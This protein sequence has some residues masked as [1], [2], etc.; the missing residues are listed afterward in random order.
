MEV[1]VLGAVAAAATVS[2]VVALRRGNALKAELASVREELSRFDGIID[3]EGRARTIEAEIAQREEVLRYLVAQ[4]G[5]DEAE[6]AEEY[7]QTLAML[8]SHANKTAH[9]VS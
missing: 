7:R 9:A 6:E 8:R 1:I 2:T 4:I 5:K 3:V